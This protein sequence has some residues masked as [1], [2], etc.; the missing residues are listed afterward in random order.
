[1]ADQNNT[2]GSRRGS[3]GLAM[4]VGALAVAVLVIG[5]FVFGG[6]VGDGEKDVNIRV[7][8]PDTGGGNTSGGEAPS[9][10]QG[11]QGQ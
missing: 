9:G 3:T 6:S 10:Q 1:M 8:T 11:R 4:M 5:F 7:E 2:T